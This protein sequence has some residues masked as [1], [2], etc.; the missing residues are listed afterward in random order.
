MYRQ[1]IVSLMYLVNTRRDICFDVNTHSQY[2][3]DSR[4]HWVAM[5]NVL[6][7]LRGMAEYGLRYVQG[8]GV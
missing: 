5:K 4:V 1:L 3:V 2:M 6:R 8:G 7:Y